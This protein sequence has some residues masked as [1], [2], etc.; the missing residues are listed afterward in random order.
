MQCRQHVHDHT[1]AGGSKIYRYQFKEVISVT[2]LKP[3]GAGQISSI[4]F[5]LAYGFAGGRCGYTEVPKVLPMRLL[6][7]ARLN[8]PN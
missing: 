6:V 3:A 8:K 5:T 7:A 2:L 4:Q 1:G